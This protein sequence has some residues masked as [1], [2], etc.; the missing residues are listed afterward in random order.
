MKA[1]FISFHE[2]LRDLSMRH[3]MFDKMGMVGL[4][5]SNTSLVLFSKVSFDVAY[6]VVGGIVST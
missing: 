3:S 6:Q 4:E 2:T 5:H 1:Y